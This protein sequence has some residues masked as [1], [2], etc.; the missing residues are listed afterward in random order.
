MEE[1]SKE[2]ERYHTG[3]MSPEEEAAFETRIAQ[4][5]ELQAEV[6]RDAATRHIADVFADMQMRAQVVDAVAKHQTRQRR[7]KIIAFTGIAASIALLCI[8]GWA[9]LGG[10]KATP[11]ELAKEYA[12]KWKLE[13]SSFLGPEDLR[14]KEA[15]IDYQARRFTQAIQN[16]QAVY[17]RNSNDSSN[18]SLLIG[19]S[20]L[21][22]EDY[23]NAL[24]E[25]EKTMGFATELDDEVHW[26][27]AVA[28]LAM[29]E[30]DAAIVDLNWLLD[31]EFKTPPTLKAL[32]SELKTKVQALKQH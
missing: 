29:L 17:C 25:L 8:V 5:P 13:T 26:G 28:K 14:L 22:L 23:P 4:D 20:Y 19:Y 7:R 6:E 18:V 9:F 24:S 1:I 16:A 21:Q 11:V 2:I 32:A 27:L 31:D 10:K 15:R 30:Y 3:Q 12:T